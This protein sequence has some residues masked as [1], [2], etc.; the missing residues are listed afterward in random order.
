LRLRALFVAR[1]VRLPT[2]IFVFGEYEISDYLVVACE[3][4]GS[5][6]YVDS[7]R[8]F[9]LVRNERLFLEPLR[10]PWKFA[11]RLLGGPRA[12]TFPR[13]DDTG[14]GKLQYR[15]VQEPIS[16]MPASK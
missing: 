16:S 15:E 1:L 10:G 14:K 9:W 12:L 4:G 11:Y 13:V 6:P 7:H 2:G 8:G 5:H 3:Q